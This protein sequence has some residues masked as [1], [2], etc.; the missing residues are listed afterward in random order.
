MHLVF[1]LVDCNASIAERIYKDKYPNDL[2]PHTKKFSSIHEWR[3]EKAHLLEIII[4]P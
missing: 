4:L 3:C 1:V 2:V